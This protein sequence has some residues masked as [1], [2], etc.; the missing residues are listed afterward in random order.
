MSTLMQRFGRR[1]RTSRAEGFNRM[2]ATVSEALEVD[3]E[4]ARHLVD[5]MVSSGLIGFERAKEPLMSTWVVTGPPSPAIEAD[6][7]MD[8]QSEPGFWRIG[9]CL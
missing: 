8:T 7:T 3:S 4:T 6:G 9:P 1:L 5:A 2:V